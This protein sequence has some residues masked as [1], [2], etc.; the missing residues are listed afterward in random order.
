MD[1]QDDQPAE[2][3]L[4]GMPRLRYRRPEDSL[5]DARTN[6]RRWWWE[7][8]RLSKDYWLLCQTSAPG[9]VATQDQALRRVYRQFGDVFA[10][11]FDDWWLERGVRV[12]RERDPFPKVTEVPDAPAKRS[13][14]GPA[15][16]SIWVEIPLKLSKRTIQ[17]QIGKLLEAHN[18]Q[19]L[20]RRIELTT[21]EFKINPVQFGTHTLKKI[22]EVHTLHRW[23]V[24]RHK[25]LAQ[26]DPE[27]AAAQERAD[28]FRIGKLLKVSPSNESL[29]G[30]AEVVR[31]R[32]NR[33][34][35]GVRRLLNH[36]DLL[37]ANVE[38]GV[39]PSYKPLEPSDRPRFTPRQL[40]QHAELEAKW[41]DL[42]L[43]SELSAEKMDAAAGIRYEEPERRRQNNL[44]Q[45][46]RQ[47]RV[48]RRDP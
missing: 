40:A 13:R 19:R 23:L 8:L 10:T 32:L 29:L 41:W 46:P 7:F 4:K 33:M 24:Q 27:Q 5:A 9:D 48:V 14:Q 39:F 2:H 44:L 11:N 18:E 26:H 6:L 43:V 3:M 28:L 20:S 45:D 42:N 38:R 21:A 31:A 25:W 22:H 34:R 37:I 1:P 35:V 47:R 12:F 17:R 16:D 30:E 15:E 36:G